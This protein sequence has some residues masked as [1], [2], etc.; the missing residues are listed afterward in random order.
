MNVNN[1]L[2]RI[3]KAEVLTL[4]KRVLL[5]KLKFPQLVKNF[6]QFLEPESSSSRPQELTTYPYLVPDDYCPRPHPI[7]WRPI[8]IS[9]THL[10]LRLASWLFPQVSPCKPYGP[11]PFSQMGYINL[12]HSRK[13]SGGRE[14][15]V[16][17]L[18]QE[19]QCTGRD[20]NQSSPK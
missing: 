9:S 3:W 15:P 18:I 1:E 13:L 4:W 7:S 16:K 5:Q 10:R 17:N 6:P 12:R 20:P 2:E 19:S 8:L 11:P 14:K